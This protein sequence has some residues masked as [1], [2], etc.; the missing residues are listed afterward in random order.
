[1]KEEVLDN[2][3][4]NVDMQ[5]VYYAVKVMDE[6]RLPIAYVDEDLYDEVHDLLEEYAQ[7][8]D[9]PEGWWMNECEIEEI[10]FKL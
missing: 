10:I 5:R 3:R 2:I 6:Q 1:M 8:N 7:D 9:L 4:E